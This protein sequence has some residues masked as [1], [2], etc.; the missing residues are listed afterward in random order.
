[1]WT[2]HQNCSEVTIFPERRGCSCP[3]RS[4]RSQPDG[5]GADA[6]GHVARDQHGELPE[7]EAVHEDQRRQHRDD[8]Q[9]VADRIEQGAEAG[10][11]AVPLRHPAVE[12]VGDPGGAK[13]GDGDRG[14]GGEVDEG[15]GECEPR[16]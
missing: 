15:G 8:E 11:L 2:T 9:P 16:E 7:R 14:A 6:V 4:G 10:L 12:P 1:M 5:G 13:D 3:R